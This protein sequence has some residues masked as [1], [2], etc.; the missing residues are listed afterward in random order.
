VVDKYRPEQAKSDQKG[1]H[2]SKG[3]IGRFRQK[4][5]TEQQ[6]QLA[7]TF[8]EYLNKRGYEI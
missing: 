6:Q 5:S 8:G 7:Q 4:L 2:F 3:K 1:I